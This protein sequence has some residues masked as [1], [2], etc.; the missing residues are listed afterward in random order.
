MIGQRN[1]E[2]GELSV[3]VAEVA[4]L[5]SSSSLRGDAHGSAALRGVAALFCLR[6]LCV[7][8]AAA[9]LPGRFVPAFTV[10]AS[11]KRSCSQQ[12]QQAGPFGFQA[13]AAPVTRIPGFHPGCPGSI[14]ERRIKIPFQAITHCCLSE[15]SG[16]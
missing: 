4:S 16:R 3:G 14:P 6:A 1:T 7:P 11:R 2:A 10:F 13:L 8:R 12:G 15:I 5:T 9:T